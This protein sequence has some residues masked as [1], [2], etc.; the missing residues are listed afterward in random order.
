MPSPFSLPLHALRLAGK[1]ALP[2]ILWFSVGELLRWAVLYAATEIQHGEFRQAR[3]IAAY[4]LLT[5]IILIS[6]TVITGMFLSL[7]GALRETRARRAD[8]QPEEKFWVSLNRIAPAFAIIYM[9]WSLYYEDAAD[10]QQM[11]LLHNLDDNF[12]TPIFNNVA[13]G[14]NEAVTYGAGLVSLDWRVSL[15]AMVVTFGLRTLFGRMVD[16]GSGRY[17]GIAAAFAEFS[18]VFCALNGLYNLTLARGEWAGQ[19]AVVDGTKD[20]LEQAKQNV[21]GWEAFWK[22]VA[23]VW[24]HVIEALAVPLTWL[25][26]AILVFGGS[27]V[28]TRRAVRGTRLEKGV[29]RLEG[30]HKITQS[31]VD[32]GIRGFMERWVPV[33]NAFRITLKGGATLFGLV[34]LLYTGLHVGADYLDRIARTLI[35]SDVPFM[36]L[37]VSA[38]VTFVKELLVTALSY[39]VLAA[40]FD[41]AATRARLR[42]EDITA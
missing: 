31:A 37:V 14:T 8:G 30:S 34:C 3:L 10:F 36:W 27:V 22:W 32:R 19:R 11:D 17:S 24:P 16:R 5:V 13:N 9:A 15:A 33:V 25:A 26:V 35:G 12:Y 40:A 28:E 42:G 29:D 1:C 4:V 20:V 23:E 6:M 2:L 38:P 7:R 39:C 18:F 21:P 41:I